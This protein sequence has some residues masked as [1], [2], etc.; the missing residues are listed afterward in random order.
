MSEVCRFNPVLSEEK[1][2]LL[3]VFTP[4]QEAVLTLVH[5]SVDVFGEKALGDC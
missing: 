3:Y 1:V 4:P 2:C 5:E